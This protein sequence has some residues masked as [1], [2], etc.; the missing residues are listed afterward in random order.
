[1]YTYPP[2]PQF[3][4]LILL[5]AHACMHVIIDVLGLKA[6]ERRQVDAR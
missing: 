6:A 3:P 4:P 5:R 2:A 1:M